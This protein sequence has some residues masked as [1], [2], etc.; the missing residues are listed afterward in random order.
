MLTLTNMASFCSYV[1]LSLYA[2]ALRTE[3]LLSTLSTYTYT[4]HC[5]YSYRLHSH[6]HAHQISSFCPFEGMGA[7]SIA[8]FKPS[9]LISWKPVCHFAYHNDRDPGMVG[10]TNPVHLSWKQAV[11]YNCMWSRHWFL[12]CTDTLT[13]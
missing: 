3:K 7:Q 1:F 8:T 6:V 11:V 10:G 13:L 12:V 5:S 9:R 4:L 2:L